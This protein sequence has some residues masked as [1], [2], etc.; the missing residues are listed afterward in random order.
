[1]I[2]SSSAPGIRNR[3]LIIGLA[4]RHR[5]PAAYPRCCDV[6]AATARLAVD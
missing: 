5:L 1:L 3:E 4:A 2:L 6:T